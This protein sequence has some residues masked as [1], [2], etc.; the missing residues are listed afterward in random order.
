[1][2][3]KPKNVNATEMIHD[4]LNALARASGSCCSRRIPR[5]TRPQNPVLRAAGIEGFTEAR[6]GAPPFNVCH[7][8]AP[9]PAP[10]ARPEPGA[11]L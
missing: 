10:V 7:P 1:M 8:A 5:S 6:D 4:H 9:D 11:I 3:T 2:T